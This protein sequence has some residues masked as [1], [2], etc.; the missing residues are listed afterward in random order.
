MAE[1]G[2]EADKPDDGQ[3]TDAKVDS[4]GSEEK[5]AA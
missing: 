5:G 3:T 4:E 1:G 2:E